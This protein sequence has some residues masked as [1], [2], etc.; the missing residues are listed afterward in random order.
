MYPGTIVGSF[1]SGGCKVWKR[2]EV[3]LT[4]SRYGSPP[5][6]LS[7]NTEGRRWNGDEYPTLKLRSTYSGF[8][9]PEVNGEEVERQSHLQGMVLRVRSFWSSRSPDGGGRG[10][11]CRW[12]S[13]PTV[14]SSPEDRG[15][16]RR[17]VTTSSRQ[18]SFPSYFWRG[19][20]KFP[21]WNKSS[22]LF[23]KVELLQQTLLSLEPPLLISHTSIEVLW[24]SLF[25]LPSCWSLNCPS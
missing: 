17:H 1:P 3:I 22:L 4:F 25:V 7:V 19:R 23:L 8:L 16:G 5:L 24:S 18:A 9:C 11:G 14:R 21:D 6:T 2:K 12:T 13:R 20:H 10:V 15:G